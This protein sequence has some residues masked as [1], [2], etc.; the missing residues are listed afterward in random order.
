MDL[1]CHSGPVISTT[2]RAWV[3]AFGDTPTAGFEDANLWAPREGADVAFARDD[4]VVTD[5]STDAVA[6]V[7][8]RAADVYDT[9]IP[10]FSR[11]GRR[12]V[13]LAEIR[14]GEAIL[15][16]A[17]GR[18]ASLIPA[19]EAVGAG[20]RVVGV[21][22]APTMVD[23]LGGD[24]ER[25]G[26]AHAS[27]RVGDAMSLDLGDD[28]FDLALCGFTLMLLPDP[29]RAV[30]EMVRVLRPGGRVAVSMP[31]G[32]GPGWAFLG[33]L[34]VQFAPRAVQPLPQPPQTTPLDLPVLLR[35]GGLDHIRVVDEIE[36]FSFATTDAWWRWVWS[37]GMRAYLEVLP[38]DAL[39]EL[40]AAAEDRLR[41]LASAEGSIPLH[42]GLRYAVAHHHP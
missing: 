39:D 42:Q 8:D 34:M 6:A 26:F 20:G 22:L 25:L 40:H 35:D 21:D 37:Q 38:A 7:F 19:A 11:F 16:V 18:G 30:A 23:R 33:E 24:L 41:P 4:A 27:V 1:S 12:L 31:T 13:E 36:E 3:P 5:P 9:A 32:A 10:F 29:N 15:D 28:D 17:S 2:T 14:S